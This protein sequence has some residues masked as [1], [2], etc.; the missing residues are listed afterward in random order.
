MLESPAVVPSQKYSKRLPSVTLKVAGGYKW[1]Q[2]YQGNLWWFSL[3]RKKSASAGSK[4]LCMK[5][6][7]RDKIF[8]KIFLIKTMKEI[9][10][11]ADLYYQISL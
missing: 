7:V 10:I 3:M 4:I 1:R 2:R 6:G 11:I 9:L 8:K 5:K